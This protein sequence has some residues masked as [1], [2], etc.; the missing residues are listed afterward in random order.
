M[1][2][3]RVGLEKLVFAFLLFFFSEGGFRESR[4]RV[5]CKPVEF[6][7]A[8]RVLNITDACSGSCSR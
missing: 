3:N 4:R 6:S 7:A 5:L 1:T 2:V 8:C